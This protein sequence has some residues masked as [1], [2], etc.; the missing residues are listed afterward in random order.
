[1]VQNIEASKVSA[2]PCASARSAQVQAGLASVAPAVIK[3]DN[4]PCS[5]DQRLKLRSSIG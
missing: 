3:E 1:M 2:A 5:S 4:K